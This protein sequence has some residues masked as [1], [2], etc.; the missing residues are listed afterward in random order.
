[1]SIFSKLFKKKT[2]TNFNLINL[3]DVIVFPKKEFYKENK[4][5]Y[6]EYMNTYNLILSSK[7]YITSLDLEINNSDI[8]FYTNIITKTTLELDNILDLVNNSIERSKELVTILISKLKYYHN[9]L[10]TY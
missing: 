3:N 6:K 4:E 10:I 2:S 9:E 5:K 8:N 7:K 1:M